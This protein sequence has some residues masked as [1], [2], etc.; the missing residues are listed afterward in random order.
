MPNPIIIPGHLALVLIPH[1]T[2]TVLFGALA[3][4]WLVRS[5][6]FKPLAS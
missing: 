3:S 2:I 1:W 4:V 5:K 6:F